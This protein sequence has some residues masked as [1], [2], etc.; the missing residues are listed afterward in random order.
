MGYVKGD[1]IRFYNGEVQLDLEMEVSISASLDTIETTDKDSAGWKT[2][3]DG[4][5]S[6]TASGSANLDWSATE[7]VS[8]TFADFVAGTAVNIDVG[9]AV[10]AKFYSGSGI[11][12]SWSFE[13]PRNGLATFSFEV[14]G[15]GTLTEGTTT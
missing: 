10:D 12:N 11:I 14:Q 5:K 15:T 4:D 7:N 3:I 8:T 6:W 13:G 1:N 9:S 2:F